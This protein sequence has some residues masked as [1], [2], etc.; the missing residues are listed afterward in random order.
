MENIDNTQIEAYLRGKMTSEE[1]VQFEAALAADPERRQRTDELRQFAN[2][3][4]GLARSDIR[5]RVEARRDQIKLEETVQ[6]PPPKKSPS[7]WIKTVALLAVGMLLGLALGWLLFQKEPPPIPDGTVPVALT[8][9]E[10]LH[11]S[12]IP[13]PQPGQTLSLTVS[14]MP[15]LDLPN[16]PARKYIFFGLRG[17]L[18]I[19]TRRD[20]NFWTQPLELSQSGSQFFLQIGNEKFLLDDDEKEHAFPEEPYSN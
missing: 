18:C 6:E 16:Q 9:F 12:Q 10:E 11:S 4:R 19:Y 2:D 5:K 8:P 7:G 3:L 15:D 13:G 17:G 20:D 14:Y 1:R